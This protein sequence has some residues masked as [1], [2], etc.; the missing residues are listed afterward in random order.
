MQ[1]I[2]ILDNYGC[3]SFVDDRLFQD[4]E[5]SPRAS[6][7]PW[8]G[9][10]HLVMKPARQMVQVSRM[11]LSKVLAAMLSLILQIDTPYVL[12]SFVST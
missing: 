10:V 6:P 9:Q 4:M 3:D 12:V 8:M 5:I 2:S 7:L 1:P 11:L